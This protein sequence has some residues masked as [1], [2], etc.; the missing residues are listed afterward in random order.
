M[1]LLTSLLE[2]L[3]PG[4]PRSVW[5]LQVGGFANAFGN[6]I[7]FP[8]LLIYLHNVRG[9]SLGVAGLIAGT[10]ALVGMVAGPVA[11][12]LVDRLGSKRVLM[13]ALVT[14]A[15]GFGSYPLVQQAW[16]GFLCAG[17]A[18][19]GNGAFW[20]AHSSLVGGLTARER[21]HAAYALQRVSNNLGIGL[22]GVA[23]GLIAS[24]DR[25]GSFT[26]LFLVDAA[27]FLVF[28]GVLARIR[29]PDR[30]VF[31][32]PEESRA[33]E[34]GRYID[35]LR[36]GV[37][38][39]VVLLNALFISVGYAMFDL[40]PVF[41]KNN[42][43]VSE[44]QIG[45]IFLANTLLIVL[46]QMPVTRRLEGRRRMPA[47]AGMGLLFGLSW[48]IVLGG[49]LTLEGVGATIA[50]S[51]ALAIF[52]L[53]ECI[54]GTIQTALAVDLA[55]PDLMGRYMALSAFSWQL[56]M[57]VGPAAGGFLLAASPTALWLAAAAV[58]G[59]G[60]VASLLLERRLPR[61]A[62]RTPAA[63]TA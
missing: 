31:H 19:I 56:G 63:A 33:V 23:G 13:G 38:V 24:T 51:A 25:P 34:P 26:V 20:P 48:L 53:G 11:G 12:A 4:L 49:G 57:A 59:A 52:G 30:F 37:F 32:R 40:L 54:H 15:V 16:Q 43:G 7:A 17:V 14:L 62:L 27:T 50:F 47:F 10:N 58:C 46:V 35:V 1:P 21:R 60:S 8:F 36:H 29:S 61:E 5:L 6:G 3:A 45:L 39:R 22:G 44:R 42:A 9:V 2:R 18:G 41:A 28:V 55:R